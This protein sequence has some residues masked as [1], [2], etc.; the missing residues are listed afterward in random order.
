MYSL[1]K[2]I[3][4][5]FLF[6]NYILANKDS[7]CTCGLGQPGPISG[8]SSD[9]MPELPSVKRIAQGYLPHG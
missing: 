7:G 3:I 2:I 9:D 4:L 6:S 8:K 5:F 1:K